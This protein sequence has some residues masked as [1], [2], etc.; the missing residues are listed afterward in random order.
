MW[1]ALDPAGK[2]GPRGDR[3]IIFEF[4][5]Q[6]TSGSNWLAWLAS[7]PRK[8]REARS[9]PHSGSARLVECVS[10][11]WFRVGCALAPSVPRVTSDKWKVT[12]RQTGAAG[13][14]SRERTASLE[15]PVLYFLKALLWIC[16]LHGPLKPLRPLSWL[17]RQ[18]ITSAPAPPLPYHSHPLPSH[19]PPRHAYKHKHKHKHNTHNPLLHS[20]L[21]LP[22]PYHP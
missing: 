15:R 17:H 13:L 3:L 21:Y 8:E 1:S 12:D 5:S 6:S 19:L 7:L 10:E 11:C 18:S 9:P 22:I 2:Q 14:R 16:A 4:G 20:Y